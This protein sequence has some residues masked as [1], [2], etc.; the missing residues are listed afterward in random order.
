VL[1]GNEHDA[2]GVEGL[3]Q[4]ME[5][6]TEATVET[7]KEDFQ[8]DLTHDTVTCPAGKSTSLWHTQK[9][10][11]K[12][13]TTFHSKAF[14][15]ATEQCQ[16]CPLAARCVKPAA[17]YRSISVH[18]H[19]VLLQAAKHFQRTEQFRHLY[20]Q[21]STVEHRIARLVQLGLRKA[22]YFGTAK[23]LFQLAMTAAVANFTL[24]ASR[25][26]NALSFISSSLYTLVVFLSVRRQV[27]LTVAP[28][29]STSRV[30]VCPFEPSTHHNAT[31]TEGFRLGF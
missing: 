21:R 2:I 6:N 10:R 12:R 3:L 27:V 8:I 17:R 9:R 14:R 22:R 19:E 15:F 11:T 28:L 5:Q 20:R 4:Q 30:L 1:P 26:N 25:L 7:V 18:E 23:V 16:G 13:G 24:I 29:M 31:T